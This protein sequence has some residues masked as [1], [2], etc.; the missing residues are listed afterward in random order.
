MS[1]DQGLETRVS[2]PDMARALA[3]I[4]D[5][6]PNVA[7]RDQFELL[8]QIGK[9]GMGIVY[10]ARDRV[11]DRIVA[12]KVV[13][14]DRDAEG[15]QRFVVESKVTGRLSHPG[16][17][18]VYALGTFADA[19]PFLAMKLVQGRTLK[20]ELRGRADGDLPRLIGAFEQV[21]QTVGF[22][23]AQGIVHRDLKPDNVMIGKFGEVLV[24]D[25]GLAKDM[26]RDGMSAGAG[27][28]VPV[29][30][31][32]AGGSETRSGGAQ[33]T[34]AFMA[35]EQARCDPI[36]ARADVFALGGILAVLLANTPPFVGTSTA[37]TVRM[38]ARADLG[39]CLAAIDACG[40]DG[41]LAAVAKRCLGVRPEDR[42][43]NGEEVAAAVSVYRARVE[44][45]L[46]SVERARAAAEARSTEQ[47]KR[48]QVQLALIGAILVIVAGLA[49]FAWWQDHQSSKQ[50]LADSER[51]SADADAR[52]KKEQAEQ[53]V[54]TGLALATELR[55]KFKFKD[56][57]GALAQALELARGS[58]P[59]LLAEV[60]RAQSDLAF[61]AQLD[62]IRYRK[63]VWLAEPGGKGHF[64]TASAP[65]EYSKAFAARRLPLTSL[66][67][68]DAADRITASAIKSDL[69]TAVDDWSLYEPNRAARDRL[70]EIARRA[71]QGE[72]T[73]RLRTP[74]VRDDK[75]AL[76]EL[77]AGA[78][79]TAVPSA[80]LGVLAILMERNGLD[81]APLLGAARTRN[82]S[83]FDLAFALAQW[84]LRSPT[85]LQIG[86]AEAARALRPEHLAVWINL[87]ATL[88]RLGDLEGAI[89]VYRE[90]I[91]RDPTFAQT[92]YNLGIALTAKGRTNEAIAAYREAVR[93]DPQD[94][95]AHY[96]LGLV[97]QNARDWDGAIAAYREAIKHNPKYSEAHTNLGIALADKGRGGEA[98]AAYREALKHD[99]TLVP[100]HYNLGLAL[101]AARDW[102]GAVAA[103]RDAI[104]Y[105]P[106]LAPAHSNLGIILKDRD[107]LNGAIA[108]YREA[109]KYDPK[110]A[111]YHYNLGIALQEKNDQDGAIAA[112]RET[113]RFAP[114][115]A[116]AHYNLGNALLAKKNPNGAIAAY[117]EAIKHDPKF[118][119][120]YSNLGAVLEAQGDRDGAIVA[121]EGAITYAPRDPIARTN[122]GVIYFQQEKY[123]E[124]AATAR[125]AIDADPMYANAHALLGFALEKTNDIYGAR[126]ALTRAAKIDP[127]RFGSQLANLPPIPVAP[128]PRA[129]GPP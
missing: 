57:A 11:L 60:E 124:A 69:V 94:A 54:R 116:P 75:A 113:I 125:G 51:R 52:A 12:V 79:P 10:R 118:A 31:P 105:D 9:G 21:C 71:E 74:A 108:A 61:A 87:G 121:Y 2:P 103:F 18:P 49:S 28:T 25:W 45:R 100:A 115:Y 27:E 13:R 70:L 86:P 32:P 43:A 73:D 82:P 42:Y 8:E 95:E 38:A 40:A 114:T 7:P 110:S 34:P 127:K 99:P 129:V 88:E 58:A 36:D 80:T 5:G 81:P 111:P 64:N 83:D 65:A 63:W 68:K 128:A 112:Y 122:L 41:E 120:A 102:D 93:L 84:Y 1:D 119:M 33:G 90:I 17:P 26:G 104:K 76:A 56:A 66:D 98:I 117:R 77:A 16:V 35:P 96:N 62:G 50:K 67:P 101:K 46:R 123:T 109:V 106:T 72:W 20:E 85:A 53:G 92:Y 19:R 44:E 126:A 14:P 37:D 89:A 3:P 29:G 23:H 39:T 30:T 22:A 78:D 48:Q 6:V 47:R 55:K 4:T 15:A 59:E 91:R 107:D 97:L 24:M